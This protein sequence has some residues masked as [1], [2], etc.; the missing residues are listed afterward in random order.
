MEGKS[1]LEYLSDTWRTKIVTIAKYTGYGSAK[2]SSNNFSPF[3]C[4]LSQVGKISISRQKLMRDLIP[5]TCTVLVIGG[6]LGGSY[7]AAALAR[8]GIDTVVLEASKFPRYEMKP[9]I[10]F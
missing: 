6:G 3:L 5:K 7:T 2:F 8:E 10:P 4:T 1:N 9:Y